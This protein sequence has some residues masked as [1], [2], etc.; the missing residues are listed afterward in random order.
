[1]FL[2]T[3]EL[4]LSTVKVP[5]DIERYVL[6]FKPLYLRFDLWFFKEDQH[7]ITTNPRQQSMLLSRC[8]KS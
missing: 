5:F 8:L 2:F 6:V 1:M 7:R 3:L 4:V